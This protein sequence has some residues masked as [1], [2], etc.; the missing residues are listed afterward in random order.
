MATAVPG[1]M[2]AS[3]LKKGEPVSGRMYFDIDRNKS[4]PLV[5]P[6][7]VVLLPEHIYYSGGRGTGYERQE[8]PDGLRLTLNELLKAGRGDTEQ[9]K[10][11]KQILRAGRST[12]AAYAIQLLKG[13]N[14]TLFPKDQAISI[15]DVSVPNK[16][17]WINE[18]H[19]EYF[20][21][22]MTRDEYK[23][24]K[25]VSEPFVYALQEAFY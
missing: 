13:F 8:H 5:T 9:L 20:A 15:V 21:V 2:N 3:S 10:K 4:F 1:V 18:S 16:N 14:K 22:E 11:I 7:E 17:L 12:E 23:V 25:K 6:T 24:L 19:S